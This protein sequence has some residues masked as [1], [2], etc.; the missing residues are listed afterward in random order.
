MFYEF[1]R[2]VTGAYYRTLY[3]LKAKGLE[4]IPKTGPVI[5]CANHISNHDPLV[6]AILMKRQVNFMAKAELFRVPLLGPIIKRLGAFP[7]KRG[8][9]SKESIKHSI[10]LL[11][12]GKIITIFPE[13]TRSNAGGAG[14]KGAAMLA[15]RSQA[16]VVPVAIVGSYAPFQKMT[17]IY[18]PPVDLKEFADGGS[19]QLEAATEKIMAVIRNMVTTHEKLGKN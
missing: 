9:V 15:L 17:V 6:V 5:L 8:G 18:G 19:D 2:A 3:R 11:K 10:D 7:V 16:A 14:K 13:G 4:N 12:S 1:A